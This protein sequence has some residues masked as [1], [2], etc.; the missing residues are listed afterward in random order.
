MSPLRLQRSLVDADTYDYRVPLFRSASNQHRLTAILTRE[1]DD[2][3]KVASSGHVV[4]LESGRTV[5]GLRQTESRLM[6]STT[7]LFTAGTALTHLGAESTLT[8]RLYAE[9]PPTSDGVLPDDLVIVGDGDP[10]LGDEHFLNT[11]YR[12]SGTSV[13]RLVEAVTDAGIRHIRG[14]VVGDSSLY[15]RERQPSPRVTALSFNQ[16]TADRPVLFAA[17]KIT[18]ALAAAGIS[19]EK[20]P[21]TR[22]RKPSELCQVGLVD[23]LSVL[24]LLTICGHESDNFIA[25]SMAKRSAAV[26][27]TRGSSRRGARAMEGHAADLGAE[28]TVQNG[29]GLGEANRCAPEAITA[30]LVAMNRSPLFPSFERI[31]PQVGADGTMRY[32]LRNTR[33][34]ETVRAKTGTLTERREVAGRNVRRPLQ[35]SLAG[36]CRGRKRSVAFSFVNERAEDRTGSRSSIDRMVEAIV[37]Y[38]D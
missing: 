30:Y 32:R 2:P 24:D 1:F 11:R 16:S 10:L 23:S 14:G 27:G 5:F 20:D 3:I 13:A 35:D 18:E 7:K 8:T 31:L 21:V 25:V 26:G 6:A 22:A 34:A 28:I 19:I 4:D 33:A 15:A 12:G 9:R 37:E 36:Y 38:C 29:S 17:Q